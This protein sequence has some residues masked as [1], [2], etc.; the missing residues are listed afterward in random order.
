MTGRG[1]RSLNSPG[2]IARWLSDLRSASSGVAARTSSSL[3]WPEG[4]HVPALQLGQDGTHCRRGKKFYCRGRAATSSAS[5]P[6]RSSTARTCRSGSG[7]S[8]VHADDS[9]RRTGSR[10][11]GSGRCSAGA[12]RRSGSRRTGSAWRSRGLEL[13]G[14]HD[15]RHRREVAKA[16]ARGLRAGR[17]RSGWRRTVGRGTRQVLRSAAGRAHITEFEREARARLCRR[18]WNGVKS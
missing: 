10:R 3:R 17:R 1:S 7:S 11:T 4:V 9:S 13:R 8:H 15:C 5:P 2:T 12:T 14:Q 6:G 18:R 16:C